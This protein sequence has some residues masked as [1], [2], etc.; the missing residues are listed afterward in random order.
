[1]DTTT[2]TNNTTQK[3]TPIEMANEVMA[4]MKKRIDLLRSHKSLV[5]RL[6]QTCLGSRKPLF[7][8]QEIETE[9]ALLRR[10]RT[11][12]NLWIQR[13]GQ[14]EDAN[15]H[16]V[17]QSS[18]CAQVL[19]TQGECEIP[20]GKSEMNSDEEDEVTF[21]D[22]AR[23]FLWNDHHCRRDYY[24]KEF[25]KNLPLYIAEFGAEVVHDAIV[26]V[27]KDWCCDRWDCYIHGCCDANSA[28]PNV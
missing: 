26:S 9:E 2:Q 11:D 4:D 25:K 22:I 28:L 6:V 18:V 24:R 23:C 17:I 12:L 19:L 3:P 1:M 8:M 20:T 15:P 10:T 21:E 13:G 16:G 5:N 27:Q 7:L 14:Y